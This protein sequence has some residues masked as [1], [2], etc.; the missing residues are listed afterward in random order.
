M[1]A[2]VLFE[3]FGRLK[4]GFDPLPPPPPA[5]LMVSSA[6]LPQPLQRFRPRG[7]VFDAPED[8][9]QL[10]FPP[11]GARLAVDG[12]QL[13]LKLRGGR[14]PFL[15]LADGRPLVTGMTQREFEIPSPGAGYSTLVVVDG[16]GLSD[17]VTVRLD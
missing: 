7:A 17:R 8:A 2:P 16:A 13:T 1:A 6:E 11:D 4:P 5:T 10:T 9:P 12:G 15:V 14:V 3:A